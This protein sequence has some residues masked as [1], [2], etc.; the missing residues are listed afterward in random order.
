MSC[1]L[2]FWTSSRGSL[3]DQLQPEPERRCERVEMRRRP[4]LYATPPQACS[5]L[6]FN[7][8][9]CAALNWGIVRAAEEA[10]ML[11]M[12]G[13]NAAERMTDIL[14]KGQ[15][16]GKKAQGMMTAPSVRRCVQ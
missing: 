5:T 12:V 10:E 1:G 7:G 2:S 9:C 16:G 13:A 15:E 14:K 3:S 8:F 11:R 4:S 6:E